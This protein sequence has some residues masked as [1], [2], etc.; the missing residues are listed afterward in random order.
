MYEFINRFAYSDDPDTVASLD[1]ILG[2]PWLGQSP[3]IRT[4]VA[5]PAVG[6][7]YFVKR[8]SRRATLTS[9]FQLELTR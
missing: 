4:S 9:S 8:L 6:K 2:G 1:P 3:S 7:S 5:G